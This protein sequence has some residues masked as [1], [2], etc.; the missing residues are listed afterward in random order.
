VEMVFSPVT[1]NTNSIHSIINNDASLSMMDSA[2]VGLD[3]IVENADY[4]TKLASA[5][6]SKNFVLKKQVFELLS[7]LCV[8]SSD[9][10]GRA[11]QALEYFKSHTNARYRFKFVV[12]ELQIG[13]TV[14]YQTAVLAFI[15]CL[16]LATPDLRDRIR[17]RSEF[18]G[19]KLVQELSDLRHKS[20]EHADL[21]V[22]LDVFDEQKESDESQ[23]PPTASGIDLSSPLEVFDAILRQISDTPQEVPFLSILQHLLRIDPKE[24]IS[25][26][27]W[28]S[29]ER[30]VHRATLLES[31]DDALRLLKAPSHSKSMHKLKGSSGGDRCTCV[32]HK[33]D[34]KGSLSLNLV[35][36]P[37][38]NSPSNVSSPTNGIVPPPPPP[39]PGSA[40]G[41]PPPPAPGMPLPPPPPPSSANSTGKNSA[42]GENNN[43]KSGQ[44]KQLPKLP[45]QSIPM[46]K[47]KMRT[48]NWNKIPS[49]Q[50]LSGDP[51]NIW[52]TFAKSQSKTK[53]SMDWA[54]LEG[55]FCLQNEKGNLATSNNVSNSG[56]SPAQGK[57]NGEGEKRNLKKETS[58]VTL[59]DAKRSLNVNIFLKQFRSSNEE[60][61]QLILNGSSEDFGV[62]R[63]RG[64]L[65]ILPTK[66]EI[67]MLKSVSS[68][69]KNRL[70]SAEKFLL[71]LMQVDGYRLRI[72]A[73]LLKEELEACVNNLESSINAILQAAQDVKNSD[74]FQE[75]IFMILVAG[76][77]LNSGGYAGDAAGVKLSSLQKIADIRG[78]KPGISLLHFVAMQA[79]ARNPKLITFVN[80]MMALEEASKTSIDQ[81]KGEI[82]SLK[83]KVTNICRQMENPSS[84]KEI[85][86]QFGQVFQEA[87]L[88]ISDLEN[89]L[90]QVE[91][92]RVDL[93]RFF[94]EELQSFK[95]EECF[96]ILFSFTTKWKQAAA[97]NAQRKKQEEEAENRRKIREDQ[98]KKRVQLGWQNQNQNQ[99]S[100]DDPLLNSDRNKASL[101]PEDEIFIACSP[102]IVRRR[103]GSFS[104]NPNN[105]HSSN[106]QLALPSPDTTPNGSLRRRRSRVPSDEDESGLMD[107]LRSSGGDGSRE[108]RPGNEQYGSLDRSWSRKTRRRPNLMDFVNDERERPV[109]PA[110]A[111]PELK[112]NPGNP[113]V[114]VDKTSE[115][116][117]HENPTRE[118]RE[119]IAAWF[120][121]L[122]NGN[123]ESQKRRPPPRRF[124]RRLGVETRGDS[125]SRSLATLPEGDIG[126]EDG[127]TAPLPS[128]Y[129]RVYPDR[130]PSLKLNTDI[131][132][133]M[134]AIE[135]VQ[136]PVKEKSAWRRPSLTNSLSESGKDNNSK[137]ASSPTVSSPSPASNKDDGRRS[138]IGALGTVTD[139]DSLILYIPE[140]SLSVKV[141]PT[142][143]LSLGKA[144]RAS[145]ENSENLSH[146]GG[147]KEGFDRFASIRRSRR[148]K[149]GP[150]TPINTNIK[151]DGSAPSTPSP[152]PKFVSKID[153]SSSDTPDLKPPSD[154]S[155]GNASQRN[156]KVPL[157]RIRQRND[158]RSASMIEPRHVHLALGRNPVTDVNSDEHPSHDNGT[159]HTTSSTTRSP[160]N[161]PSSARDP[162]HQNNYN[163]KL[164]SS[165]PG[166][167]EHDEG[168]EESQSSLS[169]T[170]SQSESNNNFVPASQKTPT[171]SRS[172]TSARTPPADVSL[173]SKHSSSKS[174]GNQP[175]VIQAIRKKSR[176]ESQI[177]E[178]NG[179]ALSNNNNNL[180]NSSSNNNKNSSRTSLL[181]SR[182]SL[183]SQTT[184]NTVREVTDLVKPKTNV[185][186]RSSD[187]S[188]NQSILSNGNS[189][190]KPLSSQLNSSTLNSRNILSTRNIR[191]DSF[192]PSN[193]FLN[194][195]SLEKEKSNKAF[196]PRILSFMRPT[197]SSSAKDKVD[198][199]KIKGV[200]KKTFK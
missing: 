66:D 55:L 163:T 154:S 86:S 61:L 10:Y 126:Q 95:F 78:N 58:E 80:D 112:G 178:N 132:S 162:G 34:R 107:Y 38:I 137:S 133:T 155:A 130:K 11:L 110:P 85:I 26:M 188:V 25:D 109:S 136:S 146:T 68:S 56:S 156:T 168:F 121:D 189:T 45:Q 12:T 93:A 141:N 33:S 48:V 183:T 13:P 75:V 71:Q 19:L 142:R 96:K 6:E 4:V 199:P 127:V 7:A 197:A 129:Q 76:N 52:A 87:S 165:S 149:K 46:P 116:T 179:L 198:P 194:H 105:G 103:L 182:S 98:L 171:N 62:E 23:V 15:N 120:V 17:I 125:G 47:Y 77:F 113:T 59:L 191:N 131:V 30:L 36:M 193:G 143:R 196:A 192:S 159:G 32:C 195:S 8:Y 169:E 185:S 160:I 49:G 43:G 60:M 90:V 1:N 148:Y 174:P 16:I 167:A 35:D 83:T 158:T 91:E 67:D 118:W 187:G 106:D 184:V 70:G 186:P 135:E 140:N 63:L 57:N 177:G 101:S 44:D 166:S 153:I 108:R 117:K 151:K 164:L 176:Q 84:P 18:I 79:E 97:E 64:L 53:V 21:V 190:K 39:P 111:H 14:E 200:I 81:L 9:G 115:E 92:V 139:D 175:V 37:D 50:I 181:S 73:M 72:E 170:N 22:Q 180:S 128:T 27:I 173:F 3:Y 29:A 150:E 69:D 124:Q 114:Q 28:D 147:T 51:T 74:E 5:L 54:A 172:R 89:F 94:C 40:P 31:R 152:Q 20:K 65:K 134:E 102:R 82:L 24:P 42:L 99:N 104:D 119:R 145:S 157:T 88:Q 41:V 122:E 2:R 100:A 138:L 123:G 161:V 144:D